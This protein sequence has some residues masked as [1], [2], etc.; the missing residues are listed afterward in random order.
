MLRPVAGQRI[1]EIG[2]GTGYYTLHAAGWISP[3]GSLK[4]LDIEQ[5]M[6][7]HTV[8]KARELGLDNVIP[9][10]GDARELP[11]PDSSFDAAYLVAVLGEV[12]ERGRVLGELRRVLKPGARLVIGEGQPDP[13]MVGHRGLRE[14]A[15]AEGLAFEGRVGNPLGYFASFKAPYV[16][17]ENSTIG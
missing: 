8:R 15:Q 13:H 14:L 10:Q 6:L 2:P 5:R 3:G 7:D 12:P 1:L 16:L 4:I 11:Y 9:A 17:S